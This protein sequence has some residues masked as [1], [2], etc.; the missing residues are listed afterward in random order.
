MINTTD[1]SKPVLESY[2]RIPIARNVKTH[3]HRF[4]YSAK[5]VTILLS[6]FVNDGRDH[7]ARATPGSPEIDQNRNWRLQN[8]FLPA[9]VIDSTGT[10]ITQTDIYNLNRIT[11]LF[12]TARHKRYGLLS[13]ALL[14]ITHLQQCQQ[15][16][17]PR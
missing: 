7:A 13:F 6:Q 1:M 3:K 11:P 16:H 15:I 10:C 5:F 14:Q 17:L 12:Q 9:I 8:N 4:T 2:Y